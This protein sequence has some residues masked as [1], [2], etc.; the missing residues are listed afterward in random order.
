M[1]ETKPSSDPFAEISASELT[2]MF[3]KTWCMKTKYSITLLCVPQCSHNFNTLLS[4]IVLKLPTF[5]Y[6]NFHP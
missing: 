5:Y 2:A 3:M 6:E 1:K 4:Y